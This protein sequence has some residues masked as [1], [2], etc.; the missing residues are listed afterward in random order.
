MIRVRD[1]DVLITREDFPQFKKV[2]EL[3]CQYPNALHVAAVIC[4]GKWDIEA[5][6]YMRREL[7]AGRLE[8]QIHGWQHIDYA[9]CPDT[10]EHLK[11]SI[12]WI[13]RIFSKTPT[14]WYTPW[15]ADTP[16]LRAMAE[17]YGMELVGVK[18]A[19]QTHKILPALRSKHRENYIRLY[20]NHGEVMIHH[21]QSK[22]TDALKEVLDALHE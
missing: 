22:S 5:I 13:G 14:K 2:H 10:E 18:T 17:K 21:W 7:S 3:I 12:E 11:K 8:I 19:L 1:D 20:R 16:E 15:G 6:D 4:D 9:K